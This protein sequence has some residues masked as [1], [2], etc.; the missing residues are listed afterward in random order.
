MQVR[1]CSQCG[2]LYEVRIGSLCPQCFHSLQA[3]EEKVF[4]FLHEHGGQGTLEEIASA[5][6]VPRSVVMAMLKRGWFQ[7]EFQVEYACERCG[8]MIT[9]GLLCGTCNQII[10]QEL[11]P[12]AAKP[13]QEEH[14][15]PSTTTAKF[16]SRM[17]VH[18]HRRR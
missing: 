17:Y 15:P 5:T 12:Q 4:Q 11:L 2:R 10:R 1:N 16:H 13:D 14:C 3:K 6:G 8:I 18:H 7:G 9:D